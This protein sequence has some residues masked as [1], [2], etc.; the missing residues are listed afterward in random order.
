[1][2][3]IRGRKTINEVWVL[4]VD[5][6]PSALSGTAAKLGSL[7]ITNSAE[8]W[9]KTGSGNTEWTKFGVSKSNEESDL[10]TLT[11]SGAITK[12]YRWS[13]SGNCVNFW[14][15][16][17]ATVSGTL[18]S[19]VEFSLPSDVP[20]PNLWNSQ[21]NGSV[22][23]VGFGTL[24]NGSNP[25]ITTS[26]GVKLFKNRSGVLTIRVESTALTVNSVWAQVSYLT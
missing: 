4:E 17:S 2:A 9:Q 7:A 24:N 3:T 6:D 12:K 14:A 1:M 13:Q 26:D 10:G 20:P 8:L 18:V 16:I 15:K 21:P 5:S 22:I 19:G 23:S 11:W 25:T